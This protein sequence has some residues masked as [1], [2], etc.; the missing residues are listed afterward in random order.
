MT[1]RARN[2]FPHSF[3][4]ACLLAVVTIPA[5]AVAAA[6]FPTRP[7][8]LLASGLGGA[9]DFTSRLIAPHL[10]ARWG[11]PV[12]VD[13]RPG[14]V[15]PGQILVGA[16]PDGHTLMMVG[17]VIWLSPFMR[18]SVPFDPVRDFSPVT[19][20]VLSPNVLVV[21]PSLPA[22]T[23]QE[24]IAL[25]KQKPGA[26]NVASSGVGNS[27]HLAGAIFKAMAG[28][29]IVGIAYR[30]AALALNDVVAGRVQMM[31]ATANASRA[32]IAAGRLRALAVTTAEPTALL[33]GL[34]T[35]ASAGLPGYESAAT[36]GIMTR[37]G[38]PP[39]VV[40]LLHREITQFLRSQDTTA[41]LFKAGIDVVAGTPA[42]FAAMI[43]T[44]MTVKGRIIRDARIRMD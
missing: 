22:K 37:A 8:R 21:H 44:E 25:A 19:L 43:R 41:R 18:R 3:I 4:G 39:A 6:D 26:L 42:E 11:E 14:G 13:N 32:H 23:V 29:D 36:L 1:L 9:G 27:N 34:P 20:A 16:Q 2:M 33:P 24:L 15:T 40:A 30:G 7:V 17:A 28:V 31:F 35:I 12:I 5:A 38:T 10:S